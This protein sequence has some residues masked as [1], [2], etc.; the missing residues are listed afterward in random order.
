MKV[1]T[2]FGV[3]K[4]GK[5][6]TAELVIKE[7]RRRGYSVG[8]VKDIHFEQ[9]AI[10]TPGTNTHR[11][12][13]AGSQMVVAR[14]LYETDILFQSRLAITELLPFFNHDF[15]LIEGGNEEPL[16]KI[17]TA[18]SC[19][20]IETRLDDRVFAI[21]GVISNICGQYKEMPVI[22]ANTNIGELVDLVI[23]KAQD[24]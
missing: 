22:N 5:T 2:I 17:L 11:H 19:S 9:F 24:F 23:K 21:A 4:S 20:E 14:G 10:D 15:V 12:M 3:S 7:L 1:F 8:S 16:P 18:K 6:T 13:V